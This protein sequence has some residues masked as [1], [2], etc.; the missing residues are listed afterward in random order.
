MKIARDNTDANPELSVILTAAAISVLAFSQTLY[1]ADDQV[2][3]DAQATASRVDKEPETISPEVV[4][5]AQRLKQSLQD[6]PVAVT[7]MSEKDL[8]EQGVH[9]VVDLAAQVPSLQISSA[10][11]IYLRGI[12]T[13]QTNENA[14]P[15]VAPY[16]D[17]V[18]LARPA[19]MLAVG[20]YDVERVE[21]L[22]GPQGALYGR[23]AT[24]GSLNIITRQP[25]FDLGGSVALD[26][27]NYQQK[28]LSG[29]VNLPLS[30][31]WALRAA[32]QNNSHEGYTPSANVHAPAADSADTKS[33]RLSLLYQPS[34]TLSVLARYDT[35]SDAG[36]TYQYGTVQVPTVGDLTR[37]SAATLPAFNDS[38]YSGASLELNWDIG[39]G[40]LTAAAAHRRANVNM[41]GEDVP[42][43]TQLTRSDDVTDQLD[44]RYSLNT[45]AIQYVAG[46]YY[47]TEHNDVDVRFNFVPGSCCGF[48]QIVNN[49]SLAAYGQMTL[50]VTDRLRATAGLRDT[51]DRKARD[52]GMFN[53]DANFNVTTVSAPSDSLGQWNKL[54][55]KFGTE[56]DVNKNSMLFANVSTAYKAGGAN[57]NSTVYNPETILA[58]EIGVKNR[59]LGNRLQLNLDLFRYNYTNLQLQRVV[60]D[61]AETDNAGTAI[62]QG[63]EAEAIFRINATDRVDMSAGVLDGRYTD[64]KIQNLVNGAIVVSDYSG[65]KLANAPPVTANLAYQHVFATSGGQLTAR[66]QTHYEAAKYLDFSDVSTSKQV[67]YTKSDMIFTYAPNAARWS[68][69]AYARNIENKT[70]MTY[71]SYGYANIAPPRTIG[72]RITNSF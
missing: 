46:L 40:K 19:S 18:Y 58:Y 60:G 62:S 10:G 42:S 39:P 47:F 8:I 21:V 45:R 71:F 16:L 33:A 61:H 51:N 53:L 67:S 43:V 38:D 23:N 1:A 68:L 54:N 63:L 48:E 27:G 64:F 7:V 34:T 37:L 14:D 49:K 44:L 2:K 4:V 12:G 59:F 72:V 65:N 30:N 13:N 20:F 70:V 69:M 5:T 28:I 31:E 32:F 9:N 57:D 55:Y 3:L 52:G 56:Y 15:T 17:G 66:F 41:M 11:Q 26:V 50:A 24:A 22:R 6:V 29:M 35:T 36:I 25:T